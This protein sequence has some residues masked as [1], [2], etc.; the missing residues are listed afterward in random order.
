[1]AMNVIE[2]LSSRTKQENQNRKQFK[3]EFK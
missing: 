2:N 3:G 1:M